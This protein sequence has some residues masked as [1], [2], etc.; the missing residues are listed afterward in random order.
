MARYGEQ[1]RVTEA[2]LIEAAAYNMWTVDLHNL[3]RSVLHPGPLAVSPQLLGVAASLA[4][5]IQH[6]LNLRPALRALALHVSVDDKN[7]DA[8]AIR[9]RGQRLNDS[10]WACRLLANTIMS[11]DETGMRPDCQEALLAQSLGERGGIVVFSGLPGT[12]KTS[13]AA[14][15][16]KARAGEYGGY[17]LTVEDPP[18]LPLQG[19][20]VGKR[21]G[22]VEQLDA[23][24]DGYALTLVE[25]LRCFPAGCS[26]SL[27]MIGEIR[28]AEDA[29]EAV[30]AGL[31][32]HLVVTTIHAGAH[33]Q[34]VQRLVALARE[35]G[36]PQA[37]G[38][39]A[40]CLRVVVH[41]R[42]KGNRRGISH[43]NVD[44]EEAALIRDEQFERLIH[45]VARSQ[46]A[47]SAHT[48]RMHG[49]FNR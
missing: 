1:F 15:M 3:S 33:H 31:D 12:G 23:T 41:Q 40:D 34:A 27:L 18:E 16:I 19:I 39:V 25:G 43:F 48:A 6:E 45:S 32:G 44:Q 21:R 20:V 29:A 22:Y 37:A 49:G 24:D 8:P 30:R 14:A 47:A 36:E 10:R 46:A 28:R 13:S 26:E 5:A 42:I 11:L 2:A 9:F 38:I 7:P 4:A 17:A 35:G